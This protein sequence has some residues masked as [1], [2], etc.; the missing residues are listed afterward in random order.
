MLIIRPG[1]S[2]SNTVASNYSE[3]A[4]MIRRGSANHPVRILSNKIIAL[5]DDA[6]FDVCVSAL[7]TVLAYAVAQAPD[8]TR[9]WV[10]ERIGEELADAA[11][12]IAADETP[13][14]EWLQ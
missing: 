12:K 4:A 1:K 8:D 3:G 11:K 14:C 9:Q 2:K 6:D 13:P 5:F 10:V 7:L